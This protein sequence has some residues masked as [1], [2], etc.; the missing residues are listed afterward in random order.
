MNA[1]H[2][3]TD[4]YKDSIAHARRLLHFHEERQSARRAVAA[5]SL[6]IAFETAVKV[7]MAT[8]V[9]AATFENEM[10]VV[11]DPVIVVQCHY[12]HHRCWSLRWVCFIEQKKKKYMR[13]LLNFFLQ[14][15]TICCFKKDDNNNVGVVSLLCF[16]I[17]VVHRQLWRLDGISLR[18]PTTNKIFVSSFSRSPRLEPRNSNLAVFGFGSDNFSSLANNLQTAIVEEQY[19]GLIVCALNG[20]KLTLDYIPSFQYVCEAG[21]PSNAQWAYNKNGSWIA[22]GSLWNLTRSTNNDLSSSTIGTTN[23]TYA[24]LERLL[25]SFG[26]LQNLQANVTVSIRLY[27]W[28]ALSSSSDSTAFVF[29]DWVS[30]SVGAPFEL[31]MVRSVLIARFDLIDNWFNHGNKGRQAMENWVPIRRSVCQANKCHRTI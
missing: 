31:A 23:L 24:R 1:K 27:Y 18:H 8:S 17:C 13:V 30:P 15:I 14:I 28:G 10:L 6:L 7:S 21:G 20:V 2:G 9:S 3:W 12:F 25:S 19:F 26:E 5:T 22:V 4:K 16:K 29:V 11:W